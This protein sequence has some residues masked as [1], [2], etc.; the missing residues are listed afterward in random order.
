MRGWHGTATG[1]HVSRSS[2][3]ANPHKHQSS[4][5][6]TAGSTVLR[7][8]PVPPGHDRHTP[9]RAATGVPV[10]RAAQPGPHRLPLPLC[11]R[12][13]PV[14]PAPAVRLPLPGSVAGEAQQRRSLPCGP[15]VP[16]QPHGL[17]E[18]TA[19]AGSVRTERARQKEQT[20]QRAQG[21]MNLLFPPCHVLAAGE[22][23]S[24]QSAGKHT[25]RTKQRAPRR[26]ST[27]STPT[28]GAAPH[29]C[30]AT[31]PHSHSHAAVTPAAPCPAA[32]R[33][34]ARA[35]AFGHTVPAGAGSPAAARGSLPSPVCH[36]PLPRPARGTAA[37]PNTTQHP[38]TALPAARALRLHCFATPERGAADAGLH[39]PPVSCH[40]SA[41]RR[42]QELC[43]DR[44]T[45]HNRLRLSRCLGRRKALWCHPTG[46]GS[47]LGAG[48]RRFSML[49]SPESTVLCVLHSELV[50]PGLLA[51]LA[52]SRPSRR[53]A[54]GEHRPSDLLWQ[55]QGLQSGWGGARP[56][57]AA[58]PA[59]DVRGLAVP[60]LSRPRCGRS[61]GAGALSCAL[62]P[63]PFRGDGAAGHTHF[64]HSKPLL[65]RQSTQLRRRRALLR[66]VASHSSSTGTGPR[67]REAPSPAYL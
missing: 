5:G 3:P 16:A 6:T 37:S 55:K 4:A 19:P 66:A 10:P 50:S 46:L 9:G 29:R 54:H 12:P 2:C 25:Q 15:A 11:W 58:P 45:R 67:A 17:S 42:P 35:G 64:F 60:R 49:A 14:L 44:A 8:A 61:A 1:P 56:G 51:L 27:R 28:G 31:T 13:Q 26:R 62:H 39:L 32:P 20:L 23:R 18:R 57:P 24:L 21:N 7:G 47:N 40:S 63:G 36:M 30:T 33:T 41:P 43:H 59:D 53:A 65:L 52:Q 22:K 48:G 38:A 34:P